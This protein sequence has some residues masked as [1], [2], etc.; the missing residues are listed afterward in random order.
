MTVAAVVAAL[1]P[2][3]L[4]GAGVAAGTQVAVGVRGAV[5]A[6]RW[7]FAQRVAGFAALNRGRGGAAGL[8]ALS[9]ASAGNCAAGGFYT[10]AAGH[11]QAFVVAEANGVWGRAEQVPGTAA[12]N[13]GYALIE[14]V[15]C[16]SAGYCAAG[17]FYMSAAGGEQAF[18]VAEA[19]GVWGRAE[20]VPGTARLNQGGA[21]SLDALS[22]APGGYCAAGGSYT[23]AAGNGQAFVVSEDH[24]TWGTA[25]E[26]PG[27]AALNLG[28]GAEVDTLSCPSPG[29]CDAAGVYQDA[30]G[31]LRAFVTSQVHGKWRK[32]EMMPGTAVLNHGWTVPAQV[33]CPS[34]G[35]CSGGGIYFAA[36]AKYEALVVSEVNGVWGTARKV[37]GTAALNQ[38]GDAS[39][40]AVSCGAPGTCSAGGYYTDGA[41]HQQALVVSQAHGAWG[42]ASEAPGSAALNTGGYAQIN[43]VSCA[44][45]GICSAGGF[46]TGPSGPRQAF[47]INQ[48]QGT[49]GQARQVPGMAALTK[50]GYSSVDGLSCPS[51]GHCTAGGT[52]IPAG[53]HRAQVFVVTQT[54]ATTSIRQNRAS[55]ATSAAAG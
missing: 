41:G 8:R 51:P 3:L 9:C 37:P 6:A 15:S 32:A 21:A 22:C 17:G 31:G 20:Q 36:G 25:R 54:Y 11:E 33:S 28:G 38:G 35:N 27:T 7:G 29:N 16:G 47:V 10:D 53:A 34:A 24:G 26:V 5:V 40:D 50:G 14:A 1:C 46:Y 12:L 13:Q 18:V 52:F 30:G 43:Q 49:W 45:P 4:G 2:V 44:S 19:N 55:L 48:A 39:V 42:T 23:D